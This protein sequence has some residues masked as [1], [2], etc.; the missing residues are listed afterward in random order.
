MD[1]L[2]I[3]DLYKT[4]KESKLYGR[5]IT[6]QHLECSLKKLNKADV[7]TIGSSVEKR[8]IY[9]IKYGRG[10]KRILMWSQMH[11]NESTTTKALV[12]CFNFFESGNI[13]AKS[14]L[15]RCTLYIIPI[16]NPDGA[17]YY[18]R[19]NANEVDLNRDAQDLSQPESIVLQS[20]FKSIKPHYCFNLHGQ[21]TIFGVGSS[22]KP[23]TMSFL[24]PSQDKNRSITKNRNTAMSIIIGINKVLQDIIPNHI[25]RYDD[26]FN[27]NCVG[28]TF[29]SLGIPTLL[30]EAGHF[31][32]DYLREIVREFVFIA[33]IEGISQIADNN[34]D[35]NFEEYFNIPENRKS[36]YDVIIRDSKLSIKDVELN[37]IAIQFE[38][39]LENDTIKFCPKI[40][41]ISKLEEHF[42]H[43]EIMA[44]NEVVKAIDNSVLEI[45]NEIDFV[46]IN[47]EKIAL[48]P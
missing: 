17:H 44:Y 41:A 40:V 18:T 26:S 3:R 28:D 47:N 43:R 37:D 12:D 1:R 4:V 46:L 30:F 8:P 38:E 33:L 27:L 16:L 23:A 29:Q 34:F 13:F 42:A 20:V 25:G 15:S 24:A 22:R 21:R 32:N 11:G 6:N 10:S 35:T 2:I 9:L 39:Q 48:K 36:F 5:Y 45:G 14:I 7:S 19:F 31:K